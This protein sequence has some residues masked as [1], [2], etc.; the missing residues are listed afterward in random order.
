MKGG[1]EVAVA[2][3]A[4]AAA[5]V[6]GQQQRLAQLLPVGIGVGKAELSAGLEI[7]FILKVSSFPH[8]RGLRRKRN[9]ILVFCLFPLIGAAFRRRKRIRHGTAKKFL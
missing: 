6:G 1:E 8:F 4:A 9:C 3:V 2:D 5:G 7:K